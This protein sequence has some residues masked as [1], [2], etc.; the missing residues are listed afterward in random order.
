MNASLFKLFVLPLLLLIM[1]TACSVDIKRSCNTSLEQLMLSP[2]LF[3][4]AT[5]MSIPDRGVAIDNVAQTNSVCHG[6]Y[7]FP[8]GGGAFLDVYLFN[9][10]DATK[11]GFQY[12]SERVAWFNPEYETPQQPP[13]ISGA[14]P[15][16]DDLSVSCFSQIQHES[17]SIVAR[18]GHGICVFDVIQPSY[19]GWIEEHLLN[20]IEA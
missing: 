18:Y 7:E 19:S 13:T 16:A 12:I 11:T 9:D 20:V 8:G 17:C 1:A 15:R 14:A 4:D 5:V 10:I 2:D 6:F 3:G